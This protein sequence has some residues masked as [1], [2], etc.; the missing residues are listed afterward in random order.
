MGALRKD[1]SS[2]VV[3]EGSENRPITARIDD[4]LA[5]IRLELPRLQVVGTVT[6]REVIGKEKIVEVAVS[7]RNRLGEHVTATVRGPP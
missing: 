7:G 3:I 4:V 5:S 1:L 6:T 2:S